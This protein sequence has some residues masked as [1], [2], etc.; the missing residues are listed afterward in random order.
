M[1]TKTVHG[2]SINLDQIKTAESLRTAHFFEHLENP[3]DKEEEAIKELGLPNAA[4]VNRGADKGPVGPAEEVA[5]AAEEVPPAKKTSA[6]KEVP[7]KTEETPA[8]EVAPAE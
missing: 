1:N 6:K 3:R 8:E 4:E 7:A 2:V 5:P